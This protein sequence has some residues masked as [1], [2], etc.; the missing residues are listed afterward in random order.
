[1]EHS[2]PAIEGLRYSITFRQ[3]A[4]GEEPRAM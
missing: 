2:I 3:R 4:G 1:M